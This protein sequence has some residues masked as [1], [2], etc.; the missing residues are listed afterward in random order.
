MFALNRQGHLD[1]FSGHIDP[2]YCAGVP[3]FI[4][5]VQG[6]GNTWSQLPLNY[7]IFSQTPAN[8]PGAH[9][10]L[11]YTLNLSPTCGILGSPDCSIAPV[12]QSYVLQYTAPGGVGQVNVVGSPTTVYSLNTCPDYRHL[13]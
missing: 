11:W 6:E 2:T 12:L 9:K 4:S 7:G 1:V 8:K 10:A 5:D 3:C 13:Y